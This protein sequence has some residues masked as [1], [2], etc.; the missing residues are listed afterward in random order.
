MTQVQGPPPGTT[1]VEDTPTTKQ[2]GTRPSWR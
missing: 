1:I 2:L